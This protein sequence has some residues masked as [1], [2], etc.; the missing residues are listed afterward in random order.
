[1]IWQIYHQLQKNGVCKLFEGSHN[2]VRDFVYVDDVC[3]GLI[4]SLEENGGIYN[5][6]S[7]IPRSFQDVADIVSNSLGL[8]RKANTN[9][10]SNPFQDRYQFKTLSPWDASNMLKRCGIKPKTLEEGIPLYLK[11]IEKS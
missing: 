1:M 10:I 6:G 9:Y 4:S 8:G 5:V 11:N 3:S 2:I 7:G